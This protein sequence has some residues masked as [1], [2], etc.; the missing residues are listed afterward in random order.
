[1]GYEVFFQ[2]FERGAEAS[3]AEE[4]V[5]AVFGSFLDKSD[6]S[7]WQLR[8]DARNHCAIHVTGRSGDGITSFAV[9]RPCADA[10]LWAALF[11]LLELGNCVVYAPDSPRPVAARAGVAQHL[12]ADMVAALG[13]PA[14]ASDG[15]HL[16]A[17][18][19]AAD[20]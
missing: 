16:L 3:I 10:R 4:R 7:V 20:S 9:D 14:V 1:L 5:T 11:R 2:S 17:L 6:P 12:P 19:T 18:V 8:Y 15:P 13:D